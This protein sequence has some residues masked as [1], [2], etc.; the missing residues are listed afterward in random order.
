MKSVDNI[1]CKSSI[2]NRPSKG[3]TLVELMI[4]VAILGILA[5][6]VL[7]ELQG[8]TQQAKEAAA[9]DNLRIFREAIERYAAEN[10]DTPPG[11]LNNNQSFVPQA[12]VLKSQIENGYLTE[13]PKNP[14]NGQTTILMLLDSQ[15]FPSQAD[16]S[17]GW[18]YK[19]SE[20][21][22][23]LNKSDNDS[24]GVPYYSY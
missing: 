21:K 4:V 22:I 17:T 8:H 15:D 6:I 24:Q 2:V 11:Y 16:D 5:A 10:N 9:K 12:L 1:N 19:P 20:K 13:I 3:F 14:F 23:K 18:I 7:P